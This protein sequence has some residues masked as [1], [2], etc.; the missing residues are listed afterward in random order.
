MLL[1]DKV[2]FVTAASHPVGRAIA[3]GM[4]REGA[5]IIAFDSAVAPTQA[6]ADEF[7]RL[8]RRGLALHGDVTDK[9][10]VE[11][12]VARA[13]QEF[14][15][16]D[17]LLNCSALNYENDFLNFE[18]VAFNQCIDRGPK[19]YFLACQAVGRHMSAHRSGKIINLATTDARIASGESAG[20]SAAYASIDAM[21][22]A[23]AQVMGY[24]G[25]NVNA[26]IHGPLEPFGGNAEA[27]GERLRRMPTGR[28]GRAEDV[29]G[30]ALFLAGD[31]ANFMIGQSIV[32]DGGYANAAVTEDSFR[33]EWA[34]V[35]SE[36]T[37][38]GHRK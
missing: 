11:V 19:A 1:Q 23:I 21:T 10:A 16:I 38:P 17:V 5:H 2:L 29:V 18:P 7:R 32:I 24:Y 20:N 14:G 28:L 36:F 26:L 15:R 22:R 9:A 12:A 31:G 35:W 27:K 30:A 4:A 25:V 34:R 8:G 13:V 33:P 3:L 37:I 6:L